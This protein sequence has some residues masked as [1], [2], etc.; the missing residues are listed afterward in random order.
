MAS[1]NKVFLMGNLTRDPETRVTASGL[2]ICKFGLA[3]NRTFTGQDGQKKEEATFVD[4]D[5]F[6]KT[7][8]T[9]SRFMKKGRAIFIEGRLRLD[10]WDDKTTGQKRS[11]LGVVCDNFQFIGP[12][13]EDG[14]SGAPASDGSPSYEDNSPPAR[15]SA[16]SA[17]PAAARPPARPPANGEQK[18]GDDVP[19]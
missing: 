4:V 19:F 17:A 5:A 7:A 15:P 14:E 1:L 8:E 11:K 6:G 9:I 2:N 18:S 3:V 13:G 16:R 12:R 10:E